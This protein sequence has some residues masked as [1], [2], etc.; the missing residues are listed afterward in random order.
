[1]QNT[2]TVEWWPFQVSSG[3]VQSLPKS[4][5]TVPDDPPLRHEISPRDAMNIQQMRHAIMEAIKEADAAKLR[6]KHPFI[7]KYFP[8]LLRIWTR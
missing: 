1:M 8:Y 5:P 2:P 7:T 3:A 6:R 4:P